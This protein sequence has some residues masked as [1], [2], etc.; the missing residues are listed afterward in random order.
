MINRL[1]AKIRR[2][3]IKQFECFSHL[4]GKHWRVVRSNFSS[5][6]MCYFCVSCLYK[7]EFIWVYKLLRGENVTRSCHLGLWGLMIICHHMLTFDKT[8][9]LTHFSQV[10]MLI[11]CRPHLVMQITFYSNYFGFSTN[12]RPQYNINIC[13]L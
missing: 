7:N 2:K 11:R 8:K 6:K 13:D 5:V 10:K 1:V 9:F 12:L 3:V 4:S